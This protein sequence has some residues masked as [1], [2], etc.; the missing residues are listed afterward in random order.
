MST[1]QACL[2]VPHSPEDWN[3]LFKE[4]VKDLFFLVEHR[5]LQ[6]DRRQS[7][8][9]PNACYIHMYI[10]I[11]LSMVHLHIILSPNGIVS[12]KRDLSMF[13]SEISNF[14][15]SLHIASYALRIGVS[16]IEL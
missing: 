2:D 4:V 11:R 10:V 8:V 12:V 13:F 1:P 14:V 3:V 15:I 5:D 9:H 6:Y 16:V 7:H